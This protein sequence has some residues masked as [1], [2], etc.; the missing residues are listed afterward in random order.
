MDPQRCPGAADR[1]GLV[2]RG[3]LI[4]GGSGVIEKGLR[5]TIPGRAA[6]LAEMK[7]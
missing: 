2:E 7:G 3:C 5:A 6:T 4:H 1:T